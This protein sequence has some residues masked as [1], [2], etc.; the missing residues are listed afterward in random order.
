MV[1]VAEGVGVWMCKIAEPGVAVSGDVAVTVTAPA[2]TVAGAVYKPVLSI[3]PP[4]VTAQVTVWLVSLLTWAVNRCVCGGAPGGLAM[5]GKSVF[6]ELGV[7]LTLITGGGGGEPLPPH[8][9]R[10]PV[11]AT[12]RHRPTIL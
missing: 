10:K 3:A 2:G 11:N 9:A 5:F 6:T 1:E 4:P 7:T 12:A 8:A